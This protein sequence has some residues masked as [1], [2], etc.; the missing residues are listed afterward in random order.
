MKMKIGY[1]IL[2]KNTNTHERTVLLENSTWSKYLHQGKIFRTQKIANLYI[3]NIQNP[4][5]SI[6]I[7]PITLG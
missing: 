3:E 5:Y 6:Y 2:A 4:E 1:V 7:E